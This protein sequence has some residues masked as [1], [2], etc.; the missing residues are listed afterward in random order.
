MNQNR[1]NPIAGMLGQL[2]RQNP[3]MQSNPLA[4]NMISVIQNGDDVKGEQIARNLCE[5]Y[6]VT[7]KRPT[8]G[9]CSFSRDVE[10]KRTLNIS[11]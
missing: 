5:S 2:L 6:G 8:Q 4:Q 10:L 7:R 1:N 11:L 9:R 3:Q